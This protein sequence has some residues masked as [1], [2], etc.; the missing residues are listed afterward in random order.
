ML[1]TNIEANG[2]SPGSLVSNNDS[3]LPFDL[4][5]RAKNIL[6][7]LARR[8]DCG[9]C[10]VFSCQSVEVFR[11]LMEL[12]DADPELGRWRSVN[13]PKFKKF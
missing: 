12:V 13:H 9:D 11:I 2:S 8:P 1:A 6:L 4:A 10:K 3:K 7:Q 5:L